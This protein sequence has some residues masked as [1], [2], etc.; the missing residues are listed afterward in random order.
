M[1]LYSYRCKFC[2]SDFGLFKSIANRMQPTEE[3]CPACGAEHSV[4]KT[5]NPTPLLYSVDSSM[6]TTDSFNS[7]MQEIKARSGK[8]NTIDTKVGF[9]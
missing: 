5:L 3:P 2:G 9:R 8:G 7:R 1:P 6:K 4:E